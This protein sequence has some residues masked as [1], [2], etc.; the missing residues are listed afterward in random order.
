M[1]KESDGWRPRQSRQP[2]DPDA[3]ARI[4]Q[5][6]EVFTPPALVNEMLDRLPVQ[7]WRDPFFTWLEPAAGDGAFLIEI[8]RRLMDG[9]AQIVREAELR[10]RH[11]IQFMLYSVEIQSQHVA[12]ALRRL[13]AEQLKHN[14]HLADFLGLQDSDWREGSRV[15]HAMMR[16]CKRMN[17]EAKGSLANEGQISVLD[18]KVSAMSD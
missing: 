6:G 9:L 18:A 10:H 12:A 3:K 11:I 1:T 4:K 7:V 13:D 8:H 2:R 14:L 16:V 15:R 5:F 17:D